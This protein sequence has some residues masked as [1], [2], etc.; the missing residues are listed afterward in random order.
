MASGRMSLIDLSERDVN[1]W[2]LQQVVERGAL[3]FECRK[4]WHFAH[5]DVPELIAR[6]GA[7]TVVREVRAKTRCSVCFGRSVRS[8]VRLTAGRQELTWVPVPPRAGR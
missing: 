8:L 1:K 4:C 2:T 3:A 7:D 5:V 6:F